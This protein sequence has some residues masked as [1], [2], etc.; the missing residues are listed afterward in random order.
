MPFCADEV[1][2]VKIQKHYTNWIH[3]GNILG[4][5]ILDSSTDEGSH[6]PH[7]LPFLRYLSF[8]WDHPRMSLHAQPCRTHS[9]CCHLSTWDVQSLPWNAMERTQRNFS[10]LNHDDACEILA[11]L[12]P[13]EDVPHPCFSWDREN[14]SDVNFPVTV[15]VPAAN[16]QLWGQA[17][18]WLE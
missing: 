9:L 14:V 10:L 12:W 7:A 2:A 1:A 16:R 8:P 4:K 11:G 17:G 15:L 3:V 18:A 5:P 6:A 13:S